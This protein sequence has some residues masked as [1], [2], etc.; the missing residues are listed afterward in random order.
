MV[1]RYLDQFDLF[2]KKVFILSDVVA[3]TFFLCSCCLVSTLIQVS[4]YILRCH[5]ITSIIYHYVISGQTTLQNGG[6]VENSEVYTE[7]AFSSLLSHTGHIVINV[8]HI[9]WCVI[10]IRTTFM[11]ALPL[12]T[13]WYCSTTFYSIST[14]CV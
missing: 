1:C 9:Q 6:F 11:T 7:S 10:T 4:V 13:N 5:Y 3:D 2:W 12:E 14:T 8:A